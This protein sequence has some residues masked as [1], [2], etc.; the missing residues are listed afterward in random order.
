MRRWIAII[1]TLV[2]IVSALAVPSFARETASEE[3]GYVFTEADNA[4]LEEDVFQEIKTI[5][6]NTAQTCGGIGKMTEADYISMIPQVIEAVEGSDTYVPGSLQ[7]NGNFLVW[8]TTVGIPCCYDPRME[9]ELHN[10]E[11]GSSD[12]ELAQVKE[13]MEVLKKHAAQ[14]TK[15]GMAYSTKI[16][17]IQPFWESSDNYGDSAFNNYSPV[18]KLALEY[19]SEKT[20]GDMMRYT[21][22]SATV[23]NIANVLTQCGL[24]MF[25]SHGSTDY[26]DGDEDYSSRANTNYLVLLNGS[27]ITSTDTA[28]QYGPYGTYYHA[29]KGSDYSMVD[30]TCI[31]NHMGSNRAPNSFLY[32]GICLGMSTDGIEAPLRAK[33]VDAVWGYSQSVTFYGDI[34]YMAHVM[35]SLMASDTLAQ[36]AGIAKAQC[37]DWDTAFS[38]YTYEQAVANHVAFPIVASSEDYYPGHGY[39]D[40]IQ[41]VYSTWKLNLHPVGKPSWLYANQCGVG[42]VDVNWE[43]VEGA[44]RY[45]VYMIQSPYRWE[46]IKYSASVYTNS[47]RFENVAPGEYRVFVVARPNDDYAQS[48]CAVVQV[49]P[50]TAPQNPA[51]IRKGDDTIC[52]SW[53]PVKYA[54]WYTVYLLKSPYGWEDVAYTTPVSDA[55]CMTTISGIAADVYYLFVVAESTAGTGPQSRWIYVDLSNPFDPYTT[56]P[57]VDVLTTD[58]FF[59]PVIWAVYHD[60]KITAGVDEMHFGPNRNC[61]RE[62]IVTFLWKVCGAQ[63]PEI[64]EM[65]FSDVSY[66]AWYRRAVYW[67]VEN[68][69]TKGVGDGVFGVGQNCTRAQAVT[70]LWAAAGRP[71]PETTENPFT[72][73]P[74]DSWY[75]KA[76]LWAAENG[77]TKGIG[78]GLFGVNHICTRAQIITFLYKAFAPLENKQ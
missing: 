28:A 12:E 15:G 7:Q 76:V 78:D 21:M 51:V 13:S 48:P 8:E 49:E 58:Y 71:E 11:R 27:G 42:Q 17:L 22:N 30:G 33:G 69:I 47:Y 40:V 32:M 23:D 24:V 63:E 43:A 14:E 35:D 52:V 19:L 10:T 16:G 41:T 64:S 44:T 31:A 55:S 75:Y 54:S 36:A 77:I 34:R 67:A 50:L 18:Y 29:L 53:D 20:G 60:P 62:Q 73:V 4:L 46:D 66:D 57:F 5:T 9:A 3:K 37:G 68:N 72:D 2:M 6:Q 25:D 39:V 56:S 61:T 70:F 26:Y 65:T 45:D 1:L 38:D 74:D 59:K